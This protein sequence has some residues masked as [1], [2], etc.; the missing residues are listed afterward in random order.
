MNLLDTAAVTELRLVKSGRA[1]PNVA[2]W[3]RHVLTTYL[4]IMP[5]Q[6]LERRVCSVNSRTSGKAGRSGSDSKARSFLLLAGASCPS[7]VEARRST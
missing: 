3:A 4:S 6:I 2:R 7:P 1:D 5:V